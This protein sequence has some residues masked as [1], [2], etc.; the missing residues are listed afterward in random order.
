MYLKYQFSLRQHLMY[1]HHIQTM[2]ALLVGTVSRSG[3][4]WVCMG[5]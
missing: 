2:F 5:R 3:K 4:S 1:T